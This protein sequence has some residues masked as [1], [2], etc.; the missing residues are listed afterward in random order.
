WYE[1]YALAKSKSPTVYDGRLDG[2]TFHTSRWRSPADMLSGLGFRSPAPRPTGDIEITHMPVLDPAVWDGEDRAFEQAL[3]ALGLD[4]WLAATEPRV[5]IIGLRKDAA[6]GP[7]WLC[8]GLLLESPEPI[9]RP[10][11]CELANLRVDMRPA[12]TG[13]LD[14]RRSDRTY[15][16]YL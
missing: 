11:R 16:R 14:I 1:V 8:A 13:V 15:S 2:V 10:G 12:P 9:H 4:G 7:S 6:S 3:D 5:S